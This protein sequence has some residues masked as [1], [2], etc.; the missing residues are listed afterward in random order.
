MVDLTLRPETQLNIKIRVWTA[1]CLVAVM[2]AHHRPPP[3]HNNSL[4]LSMSQGRMLPSCMFTTFLEHAA[5]T[6]TRIT[7]EHAPEKLI[8]EAIL[9]I[10]PYHFVGPRD[11]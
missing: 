6:T 9:A 11:R 2:Q 10:L 4:S 8:E 7:L 5:I 3:Y 1:H